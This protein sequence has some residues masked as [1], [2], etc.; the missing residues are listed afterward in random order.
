LEPADKAPRPD[1]RLAR[2]GGAI[3][4]L[5]LPAA[6]FG[7]AAR[8]R[9]A[10]YDA[11]ILPVHRLG[12]PVVCVGNLSTGGT[13]KT[14]MCALVAKRLAERGMRPGLLSRGY[15]S[16]P[17]S[18]AP[19]DEARLLERLLPD[20]PHVQDADRV[21]G[22][23]A[24]VERGCR[25]IVLDDGFQHRRLHRDLDLVLVDA[26]RP[27]GLPA[28]GTGE[29]PVR[30]LLPRG[31]LREPPS[32]LTR[33]DAIVLTRVPQA[34]AVELEILERDMARFAPGKPVLRAE[35]RP[36]RLLDER[37]GEHALTALAGR[38]VDLA[39]GI[40]N[41]EA[42][43]RTVRDLGARVKT[44]RAFA[45]H[46]LYAAADLRGLG[47]A[48]R[49]LVVTAKDAVKLAPLGVAFLALEVELAIVAGDAV[50]EA[51]LDAL[52]GNSAGPT[53]G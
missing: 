38:D 40:G 53:H 23:R 39:S 45:D 10:A 34:S 8:A 49:A 32:S 43:E 30:A 6:L 26:T 13:G 15:G 14:P 20:V 50:L 48:G 21:R 18:N 37:G 46:H 51:L 25:S 41:P 35:H 12:V 11:G 24:L 28:T 1:L 9:R 7:V 27:W 17:G 36:V 31:L 44:H 16:A 42:F 4:A 2:R 52:A 3:E 33:A 22:G 47:E 29:A 5:R 19:N